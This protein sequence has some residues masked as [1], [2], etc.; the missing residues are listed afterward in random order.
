[1]YKQMWSFMSQ[2]QPSVFVQNS[3]KGWEKVIEKKGKY[4]FLL[5]SAVN[6]YYNQKKPCKTMRVGRL[7]DHKGYGVATPKY[8]D[9]RYVLLYFS[10][11]TIIAVTLH[12][13]ILE[14]HS[15]SEV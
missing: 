15:V 4:A 5:E 13:Q 11:F 12:N 1:M 9:L 14:E 6:N 2:E 7:L 8:S 3:E 10:C